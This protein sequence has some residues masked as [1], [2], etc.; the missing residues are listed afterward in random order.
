M[1]DFKNLIEKIVSDAELKKQ[2]IIN[3]AKC[4]SEKIVAKKIEEGNSYKE[5]LLKKAHVEGKNLKEKIISKC[6]L[7]IKNSKL[8]ARR[9]ILDEV[10][11]DS[12]NELLNLNQKDF[13]KYLINTLRNLNLD[14]KYFLL[15]SEKYLNVGEDLMNQINSNP[16]YNFEIAKVKPSD[17]LKGG[18]ILEKD[19]V[20]INYSFE[21]LVDFIRD[22]IEFEVSNLLFN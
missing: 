6:E 18:F 13:E 20:F 10:F 12:L 1:S 5:K 22:E 14:G 3:K 17:S 15:V 8:S 16:S 4:E 19:G 2:D 9:K 11:N 21:V 7:K